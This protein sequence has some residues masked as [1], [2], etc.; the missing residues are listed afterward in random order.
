[1]K[2]LILV[3][4]MVLSFGAGAEQKYNTEGY[5]VDDEGYV[6]IDSSANDAYMTFDPNYSESPRAEAN[7]LNQ[8]RAIQAEQDRLDE[9]AYQREEQRR[10]ERSIANNQIRQQQN[11]QKQ[12]AKQQR[13]LR[14]EMKR[15]A[16]RTREAIIA[17]D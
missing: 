2:K 16:R 17:H 6:I 4:G 1:M 13:Q 8:E 10:H 11:M 15:E 5:P 9:I 14:N 7:R 3:V 12:A